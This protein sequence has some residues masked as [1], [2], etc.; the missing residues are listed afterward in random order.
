MWRNVDGGRRGQSW[1]KK[2]RQLEDEVRERVRIEER[3]RAR[4]REVKK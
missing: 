4:I 2:R 1:T 3:E